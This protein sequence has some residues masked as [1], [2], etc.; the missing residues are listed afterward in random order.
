MRFVCC[1]APVNFC[2]MGVVLFL[3]IAALNARQ[4]ESGE[5]RL[6]HVIHILRDHAQV[7][8]SQAEVRW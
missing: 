5:D 8:V 4:K 1:C 6:D 2:V 3:F 7:K